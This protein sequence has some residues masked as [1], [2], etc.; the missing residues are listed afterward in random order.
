MQANYME[1][2]N[3][4]FYD[5]EKDEEMNETLK[6]NCGLIGSVKLNIWSF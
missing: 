1:I 6:D 5:V 3:E 4:L 2:F